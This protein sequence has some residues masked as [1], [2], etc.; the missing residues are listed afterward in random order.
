MPRS[1]VDL[2]YAAFYPEIMSVTIAGGSSLSGAVDLNGLSLVA[3][4]MPT[5]WDGTSIT[6]QASVNG[7]DWFNLHDAAGNAITVT[8]AASRYIQLDWQRFLGI[9]YLRIR[10]GTASSP[11][12]QT[13]TRT[14]RLVARAIK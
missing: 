1:R 5:A 12:N 7:T 4:L 8:V 11:V 13:A 9:R 3:I 2:E 14:L 6:F 10:S